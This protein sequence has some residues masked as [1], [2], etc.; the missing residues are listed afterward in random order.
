[1]S[2]WPEGPPL[3]L[4]PQNCAD[5]SDVIKTISRRPTHLFDLSVRVKHAVS[6]QLNQIVNGARQLAAVGASVE[7]RHQKCRAVGAFSACDL[8]AFTVD[9][10]PNASF[11]QS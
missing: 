9:E 3:F 8:E 5:S 11:L 6:G 4:V 7:S 1:M 10:L 2:Q